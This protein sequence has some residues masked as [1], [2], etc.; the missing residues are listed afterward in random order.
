MKYIKNFKQVLVTSLI[1]MVILVGCSSEV[2]EDQLARIFDDNPNLVIQVI[3][4]NAEEVFDFLQE[5]AIA[6]YEREQL[7]QAFSDLKKPVVVKTRP[8]M[9]GSVENPLVEIVVY[10]NFSCV[11]CRTGAELIARIQDKYPNQTKIVF[12]HSAADQLSYNKS[13]VFEAAGQISPELAWELHDFMFENQHQLNKGLEMVN[14][15]LTDQN[16]DLEEFY[17]SMNSDIVINHISSDNEDLREFDIK[18]TPTFIINGVKVEGIRPFNE[19]IEIIE[20]TL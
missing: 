10:S 5:A 4:N 9:P 1:F 19:M 6:K 17:Q 18:G 16:I 7:Q 13:L 2:T 20:K 3:E 15:K 11:H 8:L 12:K 14:K